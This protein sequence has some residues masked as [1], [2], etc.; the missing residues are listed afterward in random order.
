L[1]R[2]VS[3]LPVDRSMLDDLHGGSSPEANGG[4]WGINKTYFSKAGESN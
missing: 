2:E 1:R 3:F 4:F